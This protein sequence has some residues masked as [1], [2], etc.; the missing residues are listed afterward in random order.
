MAEPSAAR[1]HA[2]APSVSGAPVRTAGPERVE[3]AYPA[4]VENVPLARTLIARWLQSHRADELMAGDIAV[5]VSEACTNVVVH[6]YR[7]RDLGDFR[8]RAERRGDTVSIEVS[9]DGNGMTPRPDSPGLGVGLPIMAG[10]TDSF[11]VRSGSHGEG[12][13]VSMTFTPAGALSRTC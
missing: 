11:A 6:A 7:N 8:V 5:T 12:T 13:V 3:H 9:D 10:L 4:I 1:Q 2:T